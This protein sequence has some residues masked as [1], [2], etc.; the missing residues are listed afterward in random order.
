M[1][2]RA[3]GV[4]V[5]AAIMLAI[6]LA[7]LGGAAAAIFSSQSDP[8]INSYNSAP[9]CA[10]LADAAA[11]KN[12]RFTSTATVTQIQGNG[13]TVSVYFSLP[14]PPTGFWV[15]IL[16]QPDSSISEGSTVP[17]EVWGS[18]MRVTKLG[19]TNTVDNPTS[20]PTFGR[21]LQIGLLLAVFGVIAVVWA[22]VRTRNSG[23]PAAPSLNPI[24]TSDAIFHQ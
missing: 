2:H 12:C 20:D 15:A 9:T 13:E 11:G 8:L 3:R 5:Q 17:V 14:G 18:G 7:L 6:G 1:I 16:V 10:S 22:V 21:L 23:E 24:A 19:D 4:S